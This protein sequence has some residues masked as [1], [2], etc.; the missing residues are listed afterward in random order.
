MAKTK[1]EQPQQTMETL[2]IEIAGRDIPDFY[3]MVRSHIR[4]C[5]NTFVYLKQELD[6]KYPELKAKYGDDDNTDYYTIKQRRHRYDA[7]VRGYQ[8]K[9][10]Y[11]ERMNLYKPK[12]RIDADIEHR[13][14]FSTFER[15]LRKLGFTIIYLEDDG[16]E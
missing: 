9:N 15:N 5:S 7:I 6:A 16:E 3:S 14:C 10:G 8:V 13:R 2:K 4:N 12:W 1:D 11:D